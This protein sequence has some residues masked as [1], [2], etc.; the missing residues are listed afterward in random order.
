MSCCIIFST[1]D[2]VWLDWNDW[3]DCSA[4]CD[5]GVMYRNRLCEGPFYNGDDCV[6]SDVDNATCNDFPCP[7]EIMFL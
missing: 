3:G 4:T 2:G 6:G 1:V 5:G 7:G